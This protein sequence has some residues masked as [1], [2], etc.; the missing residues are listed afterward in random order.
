MDILKTPIKEMPW[1]HK[2]WA[3]PLNLC[4]KGLIWIVKGFIKITS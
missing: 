4:I 1:Y 3:K 2:L